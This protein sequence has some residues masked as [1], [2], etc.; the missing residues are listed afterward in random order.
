M[1]QTPKKGFLAF[2]IGIYPE[3]EKQAVE[4]FK[5]IIR[6]LRTDSLGEEKI[7]RAENMISAGYYRNHQTLDSRSS[8]AASLLTMGLGLDFKKKMI[9]RVK[10]VDAEELREVAQKYLRMDKS[11]FMDVLPE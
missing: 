5:R 10:E 8:E 4:G 9:E 1:W 2:Y 3:K 7:E 6:R 11:Y